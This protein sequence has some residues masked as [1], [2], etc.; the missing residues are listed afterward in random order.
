MKSLEN[1]I[2][3]IDF[4]SLAPITKSLGVTTRWSGVPGAKGSTLGNTLKKWHVSSVGRS[5]L[6]LINARPNKNHALGLE[7]SGM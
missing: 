7:K 1:Q 6:I 5:I 3:R 4:Q 2:K